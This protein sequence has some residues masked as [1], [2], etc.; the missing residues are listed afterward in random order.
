MSYAA[1]FGTHSGGGVGGGWSPTVRS[2]FGVW[3]TK[4]DT[5]KHMPSLVMYTQATQTGERPAHTPQQSVQFE[6]GRPDG[7]CGTRIVL[8]KSVPNWTLAFDGHE[9]AAAAAISTATSEL[10]VTP[11]IVE[12]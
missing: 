3:P 11:R 4:D 10:V 5:G 12:C 8:P 7:Y 2:G 1:I 9:D 6:D